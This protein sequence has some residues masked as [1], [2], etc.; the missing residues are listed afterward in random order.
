M[1]VMK[2]EDLNDLKSFRIARL[3][4][5]VKQLEEKENEYKSE[6]EKLKEIIM[7]YMKQI[8][9]SEEIINEYKEVIQSLAEK[10]AKYD[11]AANAKIEFSSQSE[12]DCCGCCDDPDDD[13][14]IEALVI[15]QQ[16]EIE[17]LNATIDV[18]LERIV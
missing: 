6:N 11:E 4:E 15:E 18:L 10:A 5:R 14:D 3:T 2:E 16:I 12:C 9:Y 17:K 13:F 8:S 1:K 7:D